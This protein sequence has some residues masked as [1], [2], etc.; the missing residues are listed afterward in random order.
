MQCIPINKMGWHV[1]QRR[2]LGAESH[3]AGCKTCPHTRGTSLPIANS[4]TMH[5]M[6]S[7]MQSQLQCHWLHVCQ[8]DNR[9]LQQCRGSLW[10]NKVLV[11]QAIEGMIRATEGM[12]R[13]TEGKIRAAEGM[14]RAAEGMIRATEGMIR[15][16]EGMTSTLRTLQHSWWPSS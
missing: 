10:S 1:A 15:A 3:V 11:K 7:D 12:I 5:A 2:D 8:Q 13:A 9:T 4:T 14:I 16:T 6:L